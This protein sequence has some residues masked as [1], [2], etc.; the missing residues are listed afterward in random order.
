MI[1]INRIEPIGGILGK[2]PIRSFRKEFYNRLHQPRRPRIENILK[3][4]INRGTLYNFPLNSDQKD[5]LQY[6]VDNF[7]R[8]IIGDVNLLDKAMLDI[9]NN[10]WQQ[11]VYDNDK[12]TPFGEKLITAFGYTNRFRSEQDRGIWLAKQLNIKSCPY[13]NAEYTLYV[14]DVNNIGVARFQFDHFFPKSRY[15]YF[16]VS[17]FNLIP[18]CA[19]C[20]HKKTNE[21]V[22]LKNNYHPYYN[23]LAA[24]AKFKLEYPSDMDKLSFDAIRKMDYDQELKVKFVHKYDEVE[25]FVKDHNELFNIEQIYKRH[26][27]HAHELLLKSVMNDR[28]YQEA[29]VGIQGLFPDKATMM[30]YLLGNYINEDEIL[31]RP[32]AKFYQ[33]IAR[34]LE[35]IPK[36]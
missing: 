33:D 28:F 6:L 17:L 20:N 31:K 9:E 15:P 2:V 21:N 35:L 26:K 24:F 7:K 34:Q 10:G 32:L 1:R 36:Q 4:A 22:T 3:K 25:D 19:N 27:D 18:S 12:T 5:L 16:S 13:C 29:I 23:S 14:E 30:R 8:I 11:M